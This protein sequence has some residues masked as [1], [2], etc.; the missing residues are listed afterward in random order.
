MRIPV[1]CRLK[2][3]DVGKQNQKKDIERKQEGDA[4]L[5]Q[6]NQQQSRTPQY[7]QPPATHTPPPY[8]AGPGAQGQGPP[9]NVGLPPPPAFDPNSLAPAIN[10][11]DDTQRGGFGSRQFGSADGDGD[12]KVDDTW[13][14]KSADRAAEEW[15]YNPGRKRAGRCRGG[16]K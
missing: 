14:G 12:F 16:A 4:T 1:A 7:N 3:A 10:V 8:N 11:A 13:G 5:P 2:Q 9:Q 6:Y 15:Q